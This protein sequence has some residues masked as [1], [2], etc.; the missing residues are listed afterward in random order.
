[1]C[2]IR[3]EVQAIIEN[4]PLEIMSLFLL[5]LNNKILPPDTEDDI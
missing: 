1:M 4:N 3:E 2:Y 5:Q